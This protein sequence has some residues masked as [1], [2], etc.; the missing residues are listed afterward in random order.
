MYYPKILT[1]ENLR[2]A[3]PIN[4]ITH[5]TQVCA[6][7]ICIRMRVKRP[8]IR[9]IKLLWNDDWRCRKHKEPINR[10]HVLK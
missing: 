6:G 9:H 1:D 2:K 10:E 7:Y 3:I 5:T 4:E 8:H